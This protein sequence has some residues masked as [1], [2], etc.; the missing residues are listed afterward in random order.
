MLLRLQ[1][2]TEGALCYGSLVLGRFPKSPATAVPITVTKLRCQA[3][4]EKSAVPIVSVYRFCCI[5][6]QNK[7]LN[8]GEP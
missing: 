5:T 1:A 2:T 3:P 7:Y 8:L 4:K 6:A